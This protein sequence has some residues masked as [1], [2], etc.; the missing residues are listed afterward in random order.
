M[1]IR[2]ADVIGGA[3]KSLDKRLQE[4]MRRTEERAENTAKERRLAKKEQAIKDKEFEEAMGS[5]TKSILGALGPDASTSDAI[6]ILK[7]YS[8]GETPTLATAKLAS[9]DVLK[10]TNAGIDVMALSKHTTGQDDGTF[11]MDE[12]IKSLRPASTLAPIGEGQMMGSG[13]LKNVDIG[14]RIDKDVPI[15]ERDTTKFDVGTVKLDRSQMLDA[16]AYSQKQEDR[17]PKTYEGLHVY[18]NKKIMALD[19][20]NETDAITIGKIKEK[21]VGLYKEWLKF[22]LRSD[23]ST[24]DKSTI[25]G[26]NFT[27][28]KAGQAIVNS[29]VNMQFK[30]AGI[31]DM[32]GKIQVAFQGN[33]VAHFRAEAAGLNSAL[34]TY[35]RPGTSDEEAGAAAKYMRTLIASKQAELDKKII[36]FADNARDM[37][38]ADPTAD[39]KKKNYRILGDITDDSTE[40]GR[41]FNPDLKYPPDHPNK[42]K[43]GQTVEFHKQF[44]IYVTQKKPGENLVGT[45]KEGSDKSVM[46]KNQIITYIENG[47]TKRAIY[48]TRGGATLVPAY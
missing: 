42:A 37:L 32:D 22:Q 48:S 7:S 19:P 1:K 12:F 25:E 30:N 27:E 6:R 45:D 11:T 38:S 26:I 3:A 41:I 13:F 18:Y 14:A 16:V 36:G 34:Q 4:D 43:R 21:Q 10:N 44:L 33:E 8:G 9:E 35:G 39:D 28:L 5:Y 47:I 20:K 40:A 23:G 46:M 15:T 2:L 31:Q 24:A 17:L 29:E